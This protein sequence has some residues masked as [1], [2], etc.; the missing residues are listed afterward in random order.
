MTIKKDKSYLKN[1]L[2][3]Y[4]WQGLSILFNLTS[5]FIVIP[6]ISENKVV[7]GVYSVCISTSI[8]LNYAD[9]GFVSAAVKYA[10]ESYAR[11]EH[12]KELKYYGFSGFILLVF[13]SIIAGVY[14]LL[15]VK[16]T[17]LISGI[18]SSEHLKIASMLLITQ[19]V[20][21]YNHVLQRYVTSVFQVRIE[22]FIYQRVNISANFIKI[23][24]I[25]YF[26]HGDNYQIVA[27]YI[28]IKIVE[29]AA[30]I[31]SI[32]LI[33]I[34]Y[35]VSFLSYLKVFKFDKV[36]YSATKGLAFSSLFVTAMW[37]VFYEIDVIVIGR[38][39]GADFVAIYALSFTLIKFL[40]SITSVLYS[41]FKNRY[42]H[43]IGLNQY[44]KLGALLNNVIFLTM[45]LIVLTVLSVI[46]LSEKVILTWAGIQYSDSAIILALL[47]SS[48]L[49][50][51]IRIP[52]ANLMVALERIKDMY[53]INTLMVVIF[54][55]GVV[56][57]QKYWG[58]NSFAVFKL[59]AGVVASL[60]YLRILVNY[61]DYKY[62]QFIEHVL[63]KMMIPIIVQVFFLI[64]VIN[65]LPNE[66][67]MQNFLVVILTGGFGALVG[68]ITLYLTSKYYR[69]MT[70]KYLKKII[71]RI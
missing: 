40:R 52:G 50:S 51:F 32:F 16:P 41:P 64:S 27:Y 6:Y 59:M 13:I 37:I 3:T 15:A 68:L 39:Y 34:K 24:S 55:A 4:L 17:L 23:L 49:F 71:V 22:Q 30:L 36:I 5:M 14:L 65:L 53:I 63:L 21:S 48:Y 42:N 56:L 60:Y 67:S 38:F 10:G 20:F 11:S 7:F 26:F 47:A 28:F 8:F 43:F 57:T 2:L 12:D 33:K 46:I 25:F 18:S 1:Y 45:P 54:W 35:N 62:F 44:E 29:L 66:K 58:I 70:N 19:A 69:E 61:L 31:F 9:I